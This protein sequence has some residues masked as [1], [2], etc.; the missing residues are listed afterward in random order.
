M[1]L[2]KQS[3]RNLS[4]MKYRPRGQERK[5]SQPQTLSSPT[6]PL[7]PCSSWWSSWTFPFPNPSLSHLTIS[8]LAP[9]FNT[10]ESIHRFQDYMSQYYYQVVEDFKFYLRKFTHGYWVSQTNVPGSKAPRHV[11]KSSCE[12]SEI[13]KVV[14]YMCVVVFLIRAG[15]VT[16]TA[17]CCWGSSARPRG[18]GSALMHR[19]V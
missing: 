5:S 7:S 3:Q 13:Q 4:A 18:P 1:Q 17:I 6:S 9:T 15:D 2:N 8:R 10:K 12:V 19:A 14:L 16:I 11:S